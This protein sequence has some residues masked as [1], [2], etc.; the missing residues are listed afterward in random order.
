MG[1]KNHVEHAAHNEKVCNYLKKSPQYSDWVITVA[2][3]SA[4]HYIRHLIVPQKIEGSTYNDFEEIF[5]LKKSPGDGRHGFQKT[6]VA[7]HHMD[8]YHDYS[9]LHEMS[10]FSRYHTYEYTREDSKKA[11]EYLENIKIYTKEKKVF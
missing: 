4:M 3:Y 9:K 6:Y 7:I 2:F 8:I 10:E 1:K 5:K 11:C